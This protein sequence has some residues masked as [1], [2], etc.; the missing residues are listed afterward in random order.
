VV[1]V[2]VASAGFARRLQDLQVL[3]QVACWVVHPDY[4][5][6]GYM[7]VVI[8]GYILAFGIKLATGHHP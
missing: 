4:R 8:E 5:F 6:L 1:A 2:V 3:H 7:E